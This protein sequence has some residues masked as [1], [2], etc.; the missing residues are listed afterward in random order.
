[1]TDTRTLK[2]LL[3]WLKGTDLAELAYRRGEDSVLLRLDS[4]GAEPAQALPA[5]T[6]IPVA[7]PEVGVFRFS[8]PGKPRSAEKD[9]PVR[10]GQNLGFIDTGKALREVASPARGRLVSVLA[11]EGGAVEY[12]QPLFFLQPA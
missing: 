7:S 1:M 3:D 5:C 12:G 4:A 11:E 2:P 8:A 10:K 9:A 6:L